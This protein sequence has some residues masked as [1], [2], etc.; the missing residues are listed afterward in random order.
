MPAH[1]DGRAIMGPWQRVKASKSWWQLVLIATSVWIGV[2][3][4][5]REGFLV[6][7]THWLINRR[8]PVDKKG[9]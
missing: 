1:L 9:T 4:A 6:A 5:S 8:F 2:K 7:H 3:H